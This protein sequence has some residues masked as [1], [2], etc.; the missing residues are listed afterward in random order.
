MNKTEN[1]TNALKTAINI[2]EALMSPKHMKELPDT[3][4][5]PLSGLRASILIALENIED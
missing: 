1:A 5:V 2:H 3:T 4:Q